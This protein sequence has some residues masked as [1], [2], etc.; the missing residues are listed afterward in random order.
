VRVEVRKDIVFAH[1]HLTLD[2][3]DRSDLLRLKTMSSFG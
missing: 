3:K 1:L 2:G